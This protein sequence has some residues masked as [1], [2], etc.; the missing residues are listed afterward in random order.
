MGLY[1]KFSYKLAQ[2]ANFQYWKTQDV[3]DLLVRRMDETKSSRTGFSFQ[4]TPKL[5][6][7]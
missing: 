2:D 4:F 5:G 7:N 1:G 6:V 3:Y